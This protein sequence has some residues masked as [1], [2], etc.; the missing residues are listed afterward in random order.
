MSKGTVPFDIFF[1]YKHKKKHPLYVYPFLYF[2]VANEIFRRNFKSLIVKKICA[3]LVDKMSR[4]GGK[5]TFD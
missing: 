5:M 3:P 2:A 4:G 1:L